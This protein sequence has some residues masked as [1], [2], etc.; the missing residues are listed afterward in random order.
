MVVGTQLSTL[1]KY[2]VL[3]AIALTGAPLGLIAARFITVL[4]WSWIVGFAGIAVTIVSVAVMA[5]TRCPK[6]DALLGLAE[7]SREFHSHCCPFCGADL[8][9]RM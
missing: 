2:H 7:A 8:R 5:L 9:I 4:F 1:Q 3:L 6:C